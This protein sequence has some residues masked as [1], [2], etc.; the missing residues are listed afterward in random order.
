M[1]RHIDACPDFRDAH[2][3]ELPD[4]PP[5]PRRIVPNE[6][7]GLA[8]ERVLRLW[9]CGPARACKLHGNGKPYVTRPCR[10]NR[11]CAGEKNGVFAA[12][13]YVSNSRISLATILFEG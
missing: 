10:Q 2:S 1:V 7:I 5:P 6:V 12:P 3:S 13:R 8:R 9:L 11:L 4:S